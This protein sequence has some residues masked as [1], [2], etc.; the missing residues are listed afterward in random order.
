MKRDVDNQ[1]TALESTKCLLHC[2]KLYELW[3]TNGFKMDRSF[4][5][6]SPFRFVPVSR[7]PCGINVALTATQHHTAFDSSAAQIEAPKDVKLEM[8]SRRAALCG[9]T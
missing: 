2:P 4:Y 1:A 7:P 3:H 9:N 5:P 6:P 8:L